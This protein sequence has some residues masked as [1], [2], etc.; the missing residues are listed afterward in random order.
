MVASRI[1]F[2]LL[3]ALAWIA[4]G[5]L[6]LPALVYAVGIGL[7]GKYIDGGVGAFYANFYRDLFSASQAPLALILG[8]YIVV[9]LAR[10]PLLGRKW[11]EDV[12]DDAA[13]D[14]PASRTRSRVEPRIGA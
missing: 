12:V 1:R 8:P 5:A 7:L 4:F 3:F 10:A 2:E 6:V 11:R 13:V 9:M 14:D